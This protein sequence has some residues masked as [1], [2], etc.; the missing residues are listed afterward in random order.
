MKFDATVTGSLTPEG[1]RALNNMFTGSKIEQ[2]V[3][4]DLEQAAWN[5]LYLE[6]MEEKERRL[7][8]APEQMKQKFIGHKQERRAKKFRKGLFKVYM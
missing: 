2:A 8:A 6:Y 4:D 7:E 1:M 3:F 5:Q